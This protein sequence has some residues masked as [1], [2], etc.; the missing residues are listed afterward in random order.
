MA[1]GLRWLMEVVTKDEEL[2][3]EEVSV[4]QHQAC[5]KKAMVHFESVWGGKQETR[6]NNVFVLLCNVTYYKPIGSDFVNI[7][8]DHPK[9]GLC[10][11]IMFAYRLTI[12]PN[13]NK[14]SI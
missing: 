5:G 6:T 4:N 10:L 1:S 13:N 2:A 7:K 8:L 9:L 12:K 3:I 11:F 14:M